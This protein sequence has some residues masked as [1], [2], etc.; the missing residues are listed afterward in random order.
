MYVLRTLIYIHGLV[1]YPS[2]RV[3]L[4]YSAIPFCHP[5]RC[6]RWREYPTLCA[7][8]TMSAVCC[9][10]RV[11]RR[12]HV[13]KPPPT[14]TSAKTE[15]RLGLAM[16]PLGLSHPSSDHSPCRLFGP[17]EGIGTNIRF[18]GAK[19]SALSSCNSYNTIGTLYGVECTSLS[20]LSIASWFRISAI[21]L[22][23]GHCAIPIGFW[24]LRS[25]ATAC[26]S[27]GPTNAILPR[28]PDW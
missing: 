1:N 19:S 28:D 14:T 6:T 8:S 24:R 12:S 18:T 20:L 9:S 11:V 27:T 25:V 17:I 15:T 26:I 5:G 10:A 21:G 4:D 13:P 3:A 23:I 2:D 22:L 16:A 7:V